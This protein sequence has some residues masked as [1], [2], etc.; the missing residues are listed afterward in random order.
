MLNR[1]E[2]PHREQIFVSGSAS[3]GDASQ[4]RPCIISRH[5]CVPPLLYT[6]SGV[7]LGDQVVIPFGLLAVLP[8]ACSCSAMFPHCVIAPRDRTVCC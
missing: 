6:V 4:S 1:V 3:S 2:L 5:A 7:V 8:A